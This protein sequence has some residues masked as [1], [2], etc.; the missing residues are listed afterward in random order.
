MY[1]IRSY[2]ASGQKYDQLLCL[3]EAHVITSYSIHYTKLYDTS[4]LTV[5]RVS[6][7][8]EIIDLLLE[9]Q[10]GAVPVVDGENLAGIVS[11]VDVLRAL[12]DEL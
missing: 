9:E 1:A 11:Y 12:R 5:T 4:L 10:V 7:V 6:D 2:Y 8:V 3:R